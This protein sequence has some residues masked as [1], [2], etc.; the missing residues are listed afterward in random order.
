M[1]GLFAPFNNLQNDRKVSIIGAGNTGCALAADLK[2]RG[3]SVCLYA[4]PEHASRLHGIS[5]RGK[6]VY[7]G[8]IEGECTPDLLTTN[9]AEALAFAPNIILALPSY[10][11][12]HMFQSLAPHI[13]NHHRV[14]NL[15]G[16]FSSYILANLLQD[17]SPVIVETN[18]APHASRAC[19]N[20]DVDIMGVKSFIPVATLRP[21]TE[22]TKSI[23]ASIIPCQLEWQPDIMAVGFQLYNGVLHPPIMVLNAGRIDQSLCAG[24]R[25]Y[26][27]GVPEHVGKMI[28]AVDKERMDIAALYGHKHLRTTLEALKGIYKEDAIESISQFA[29]CAKVYQM[30]DAPTSIESRHL[31]E[32]VPSILVPWYLLG[33]R[34][35]YEAKAIKSLIDMSSIMHSRDYMATGRTLET[36][37]LPS[38]EAEIASWPQA[39]ELENIPAIAVG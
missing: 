11:Q 12:D 19:C 9:E 26:A 32:D 30:I 29:R 25:F 10:A 4:H 33:K 36:M 1:S 18:C 35:G 17:R 15:N 22:H 31:T 3:Y 2:Q 23:I 21:I 14:I 37:M 34:A 13:Q 20:G 39:K 16:N 5:G 7:G 24:F 6:M 27:E 28:E 8:I 38:I